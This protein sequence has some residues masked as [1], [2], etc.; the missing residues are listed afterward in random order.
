M[1]RGLVALGV[2]IGFL[3]G[4]N[5]IATLFNLLGKA[6]TEVQAQLTQI[7]AV[8]TLVLF[9]IAIA[10]IVKVRMLSSLLVG[11]VIGAVVNAILKLNGIDVLNT[12]YTEILKNLGF[13]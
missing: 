2:I 1:G 13:I 7:S 3:F 10:L 11:A 4:F 6:L 9:I 5:G 8:S 12:I